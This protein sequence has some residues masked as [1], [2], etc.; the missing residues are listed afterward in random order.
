MD[1]LEQVDWKSLE[2]LN[3]SPE[4]SVNNALKQV[5]THFLHFKP[6]MIINK[7]VL[8]EEKL[9]HSIFGEAL[10][11]SRICRDRNYSPK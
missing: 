4:H 1:L 5:W 6:A 8:G 10:D 11:L 7:S 9:L 2:C 3:A